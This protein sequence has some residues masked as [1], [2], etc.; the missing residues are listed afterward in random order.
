MSRHQY[1]GEHMAIDQKY[2]VKSDL[3]K[4]SMRPWSHLTQNEDTAIQN[5][6]YPIFLPL[7]KDNFR[8]CYF[9]YP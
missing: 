3:Q 5:R 6:G 8:W 9:R 1:N 4:Q 2:A 7:I